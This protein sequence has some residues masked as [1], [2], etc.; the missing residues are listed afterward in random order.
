MRKW[1]WPG[2]SIWLI[3]G[4]AMTIL[5]R[6]DKNIF[7]LF[8]D[9]EGPPASS[10][11]GGLR[12]PRSQWPAASAYARHAQW[13]I[14]RAC[15]S[16]MMIICTMPR[17]G[18]TGGRVKRQFLCG[19]VR[20]AFRSENGSDSHPWGRLAVHDHDPLPIL[21]I[22]LNSCN[23]HWRFE[24]TFFSECSV[25]VRLRTVILGRSHRVDVV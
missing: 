18:L 1:C 9:F 12:R 17:T 11:P 23:R 24:F 22:F 2:G 4:V 14:L 15:R 21:A 6:R 16:D 7:P 25:P 3:R 5:I 13:P 8:E 10:D 19:P 20:F